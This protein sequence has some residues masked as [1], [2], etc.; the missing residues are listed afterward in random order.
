VGADVGIGTKVAEV[1]QQFTQGN[2]TVTNNPLDMAI[3]GRGFFRMDNGG[4]ISYT[5]NGQM[6]VD[7]SGFVVNS[8]SL[9][10]TGYGVDA[11]HNV[12]TSAPIPLQLATGD[13]APRATAASAAT[14]NLD[15]RSTAIA[16]AFNPANPATYT[17]TTS[18][19]IYDSLGNS[20]SLTMYFT[21]TAVPGQWSLN[22][23]IDGGPL[24]DVNLGAGAG[25]PILLNFNSS[26]ALTTA[27]PVAGV[28]LTL[29]NGAATPQTMSLDLTGTTQFGSDFGV[30]SLS[31]DGY[32]SGRLVGYDVADNGIVSGRYTNGQSN[33]L[34][35]LILVNFAN[36]QGL[37]PKGDNQWEE[38]YASGVPVVGTPLS[39][40]LGNIQAAAVEES[41]VDLT[42]EL[43]NMI[44]AQRVYQANAQTIKTQDQV[45]QTIVNLR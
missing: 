40:S 11:N 21:K 7:A 34:G 6:H 3:N 41:N 31:Q 13:I 39:G 45:L 35:Q 2:V 17:S 14:L 16:A 23:N 44:T 10:L 33:Q 32:T 20:H 19:A 8:Q 27:M 22:A 29:A 4:T 15:S 25:T 24:T 42:Q 12:I 38:T 1:Q 36:Q 43:V 5:R 26:G 37:R 9:K 18:S 28:Q 30:T